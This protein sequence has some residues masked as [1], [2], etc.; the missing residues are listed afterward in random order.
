MVNKVILVGTLTRDAE[1]FVGARGPVTRMR[2]RTS[3]SWQDADGTS[4]DATEFHN[5]VAFDRHAEICSMYG[6]KDVSL[7]VEG[8]LRTREYEGGD[9][10]RRT[11]T[12]VVVEVVCVLGGGDV[13]TGTASSSDRE[14]A[15]ATAAEG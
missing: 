7:Y 4:H 6:V 11:A 9:G 14:P 12:E 15:P 2:L 10:L 1:S 3:R 13:T 8:R 5:V